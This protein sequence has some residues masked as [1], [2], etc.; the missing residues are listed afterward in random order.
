PG[1]P[2]PGSPPP[3]SP[4]PGADSAGADPEKTVTDLPA[5]ATP[6]DAADSRPTVDLA[7]RLDPP[8]D[9]GE[10]DAETTAVLDGQRT[11]DLSGRQGR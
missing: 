4:P 1:S 11:V 10:P 5:P 8:T 9:D 7:A 6:D 2:P 3:G